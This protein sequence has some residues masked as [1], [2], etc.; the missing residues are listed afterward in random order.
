MNDVE[1]LVGMANQIGRFFGADAD[2]EAGVRA[3]A[4]HL[5]SFWHP[6]MRRR[7]LDH[8]A[9]GGTGLTDPVKKAI[10]RLSDAAQ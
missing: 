6:N 2:E 1:R 8:L 10:A 3:I 9:D 7:I 4:E 5:K